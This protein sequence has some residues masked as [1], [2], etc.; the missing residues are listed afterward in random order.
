MTYR[1]GPFTFDGFKLWRDGEQVD[2]EQQQIEVL[3]TLIE[4]AESRSEPY[5]DKEEMIWRLFADPDR[6]GRLTVNDPAHSLR[7]AVGNL[8]NKLGER[9]D[10]EP[11]ITKGRYRL[12]AKIKPVEDADG[13]HAGEEAPYA[14]LAVA[15]ADPQ[16][17]PYVGPQPFPQERSADFFGREEEVKDLVCLLSD[18]DTRV[19]ALF[20]PSGAGKTS[21]LNT[22]LRDAL[23]RRGHQVLPTAR[24]G[25]PT[26]TPTPS[27]GQ[28]QYTFAAVVSMEQENE[29]VLRQ[30]TLSWA[31]YLSPKGVGQR[32]VLV[33]DQLEE[34]VTI[35]KS[36]SPRQKEEFFVELR[37]AVARDPSLRVLLAFREE[38]LAQLQ[39]LAGE[40]SQMW[41]PYPLTLLRRKDC[42]LAIKEPASRHG[43]KFEEDV[44]RQL[45]AKLTTVR[46]EDEWG[47]LCEEPGE[48]V[49][50][51]QLQLICDTLWRSLPAHRQ[52]IS[53][54]DLRHASRP[55]SP[56]EAALGTEQTIS[57]FVESVL[58][59]FC[60]QA[61]QG[62]SATTC[63]AGAPAFPEELTILGCLQFVSERGMR[64]Q[65]RRDKDWTGD[66]PNAVADGLAAHQ[67]LRVEQRHGD[68]W[69]ELAHDTLIRP[70]VD[71]ANK[72]DD[73]AM[74]AI[75]STVVRDLAFT[76]RARQEGITE[77]AIAQESCLI[78]VARDGSR[79]QASL[80]TLENTS[81]RL[82]LW[83]IEA[84]A[85]RGI[86]RK[87]QL[88]GQAGYELTHWRMALALHRERF[89]AMDRL[90]NARKLLATH[91]DLCLAAD[92]APA[93]WYQNSDNILKD[94]EELVGV[95]KLSDMEARF[96]LCASLATGY[97]L[98]EFVT[99]VRNK[100]PELAADTLQESVRYP[101]DSNVR[102]H[103]ALAL[104][105]FSF[106][107][108]QDILLDL[109][110]GDPDESVQHAAA[111]VLAKLEKADYLERL[112]GLLDVPASRPD[113]LKALA[114]I[115]DATPAN[116]GR[117]FEERRKQL[118]LSSRL[119]L[120][121]KLTGIRWKDAKWRVLVALLI[122]LVSTILVTVPPR[123]LLATFGLTITQ[124]APMGLFEG[125]FQGVAGAIIW[126]LFIGGSLLCWWFVGER[127][128]PRQGR[129][130]TVVGALGGLA[131]GVVNT[132][133]LILVYGP[134]TLAEMRWLPTKESSQLATLTETGLA[135]AMPLYGVLVGLGVGLAARRMRKRWRKSMPEQKSAH[136]P[137]EIRVVFASIVKQTLIY[138][139][140]ILTPLVVAA[141]A[142][143]AFLTVVP[144]QP[145][146]YAPKLFGEALSLYFGGIGLIIGLFIGLHILRKG[147]H[148]PGDEELS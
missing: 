118:S 26:G 31:A 119:R 127:R 88:Q 93:I 102:R 100:F 104:G 91:L 87:V 148:I 133:A 99:Q 137:S 65:V 129:F 70:V 85:S 109:A 134:G 136:D 111:G 33:I 24:V 59:R 126:S 128:R 22:A 147:L 45:V 123:A 14:A 36:G 108:R 67:F 38:Y 49:E 37:E 112:F 78:F 40:L 130:S 3:S 30:G 25:V 135:L 113:A 13:S 90:Y 66:L 5:V 110:L 1:F 98:E 32:N 79:L 72:I 124:L 117:R 103:T 9:P 115:H 39:R 96:A 56:S 12:D 94:V 53:W 77:A 20:S 69:Y 7:V 55:E 81:V 34:I 107:Q 46:Y 146:D 95:A 116:D 35:D 83:S 76:P 106:E 144:H 61:T 52:N 71:R 139:W 10:G 141:I 75:F 23:I 80:A 97:H 84:L 17:S 29:A 62:A 8:R 2:I 142:F 16:N 114:W 145:V 6:P 73:D 50:P 74:R 27:P 86:L 125:A 101:S 64:T 131:G 54:G 28:N 41:K 92:A 42:E 51:L 58:Y 140:F 105:L 60:E 43:V 121:A 47:T 89:V 19:V 4:W 21:L 48:F 122:T 143:R 138:G 132:F 44:L 11:Y 18:P 120:R 57:R 15:G 68:R 63:S 82:P